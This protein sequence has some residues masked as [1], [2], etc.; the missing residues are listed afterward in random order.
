MIYDHDISPEPASPAQPISP[1]SAKDLL[2]RLQLLYQEGKVVIEIRARK[3][4]HMDSPVAVEA[5]SNIWAY[6][7]F[8]VTGLVWW[9]FGTIPGVICAALGIAAYFTLGRLYVNRRIERRVREEA[10]YDLDKWRKLW[11]F[12]GVTLVA[13]G[14]PGVAP[15]AAP[16]GNWIAFARS[17][18]A[19]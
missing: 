10:F 9:Q 7:L 17:F 6:G 3:L 16:D 18:P 19:A 4:D 12:G 15:C 1:E 2:Q 8:V 11:R 14:V 5:D 13:M